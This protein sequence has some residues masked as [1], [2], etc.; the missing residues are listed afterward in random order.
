MVLLYDPGRTWIEAI[1]PGVEVATMSLWIAGNCFL[2]LGSPSTRHS[3]PEM[4][5]AR[6]RVRPCDH[7]RIPARHMQRLDEV[8]GVTRV[9][10]FAVNEFLK[11]S[12][13]L[14]PSPLPAQQQSFELKKHQVVRLSISAARVVS[15]ARG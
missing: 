14:V 7:L 5:D 13:R 11:Q 15:S 2:P 6:M 4:T 3:C 9:Q 1:A 10:W 12:N 8:D